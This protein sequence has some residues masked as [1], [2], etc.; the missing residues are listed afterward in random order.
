MFRAPAKRP[1]EGEEDGADNKTSADAAAAASAAATATAIAAAAAGEEESSTKK[2]NVG[3]SIIPQ[4]EIATQLG[5]EGGEGAELNVTRL[6]GRKRQ[7]FVVFSLC[8][9]FS[10]LTLDQRTSVRTSL[11]GLLRE[12]RRRRV[13]RFPRTTAATTWS[14]ICQ[15]KIFCIFITKSVQSVRTAAPCTLEPLPAVA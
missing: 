7:G 15:S 8:V 10:V 5:P 11:L 4:E 12:K 14:L 6:P 13:P 1:R 3:A 2:A 9:C